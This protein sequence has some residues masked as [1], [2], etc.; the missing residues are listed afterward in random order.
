MD[1]AFAI[2]GQGGPAS[3]SAPLLL[4]VGSSARRALPEEISVVLC[5]QGFAFVF[6]DRGQFLFVP[7]KK[8]K[9]DSVSF[10]RAGYYGSQSLRQR[11]QYD[12]H[13]YGCQAVYSEPAP[14]LQA[15]GG[16]LQQRTRQ[17]SALHAELRAFEFGG[18]TGHSCGRKRVAGNGGVCRGR[19]D[20]PKRRRNSVRPDGMVSL[21]YEFTKVCPVQRPERSRH[22][23][24]QLLGWSRRNTG[25]LF[26]TPIVTKNTNNLQTSGTTHTHTQEQH[27][28]KLVTSRI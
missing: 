27:T 10:R 14:C 13:D 4:A 9:G 20:R 1:P 11:P 2:R 7:C 24:R 6:F 22:G 23:R 8:T 26:S 5:E 28:T 25:R 17:L 21:H 18:Y 12:C 19:L 16:C 15:T 3:P